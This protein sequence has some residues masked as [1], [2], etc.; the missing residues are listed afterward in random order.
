MFPR[1]R[2]VAIPDAQSGLK[3]LQDGRISV[4]ATTS[5]SISHLLM[6]AKDDNLE[7]RFPGGGNRCVLRRSDLQQERR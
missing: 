6:V 4:L 1:E 2:I 5:L 3:M 7:V